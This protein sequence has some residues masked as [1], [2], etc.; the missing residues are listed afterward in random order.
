MDVLLM[1]LSLCSLTSSVTGATLLMTLLGF[2]WAIT[3]WVPF[4]LVCLSRNILDLHYPLTKESLQLAEAIHSTPDAAIGDPDFDDNQSILL[5]DTSTHH[6]SQQHDELFAVEDS[7]SD[8]VVVDARDGAE[9]GEREQ[10]DFSDDENDNG[11]EHDADRQGL[12]GNAHA[13]RSWVDIADLG[14]NMVQN[15]GA[16]SGRG[17]LSAKAGIILV[18]R[19]SSPPFRELALTSFH[20]RARAFKTSS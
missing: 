16:R 1:L 14:E 19:P 2:P 3:L 20:V 11:S 12:M 5:A 4:S 17:S 8:E 15:G 6:L 13:R 10:D 7:D 18:R 9:L